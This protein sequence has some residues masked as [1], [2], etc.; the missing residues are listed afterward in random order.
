MIQAI[1]ASLSLE[2]KLACS[3][4]CGGSL[5]GSMAKRAGTGFGI[6]KWSVVGPP[7]EGPWGQAM[8]WGTFGLTENG[9]T[10]FN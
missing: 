2:R 5:W 1:E 8:I 7:E 3:Q 4:K 10:V 6:P 9:A